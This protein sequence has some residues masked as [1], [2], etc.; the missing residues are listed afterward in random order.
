MP[1]LRPA[2]LLREDVRPVSDVQRPDALRA[3]E[4]VR[5]ERDEIRAQ[6]LDVEVD[7]RR[8]LDRVD[9][10]RDALARPDPRGDLRDRLDRADL[11]VGE[12]DRDED[13]PVVERRLELVGI[14]PAVP[15]DRQLDDLEAELLEIAQRVPDGVMLDRRGHDPVAARLAG[16]RRAL[17]R[18]VVRLGAARREDDLATARVEARGDPFVGLVERR[19]ARRARTRA[20]SSRSR[21]TSVR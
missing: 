5:P 11:V 12:H 20:P 18:E 16:P 7:V 15:V 8:R 21:T 10:E 4:L 14:D 19:P 17:Q 13:R 9:V 1:L 2:L 3:F 6:R